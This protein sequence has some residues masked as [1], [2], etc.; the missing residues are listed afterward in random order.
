MSGTFRIERVSY[1]EVTA[2]NEAEALDLVY[3]NKVSPLDMDHYV[4]WKEDA[5]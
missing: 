2:A 1:Y 4:S 3:D 5:A